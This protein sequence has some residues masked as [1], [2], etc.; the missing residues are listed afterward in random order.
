VVVFFL[1]WAPFHAQRLLVI[2]VRRD[3]WTPELLVLQNG[4]YYVSGV[5]YYVSSVVNPILYSIMSLK[6]RQAFRNIFRS[7]CCSGWSCLRGR[8][9][10]YDCQR[11]LRRGRP[12]IKKRVKT[13]RFSVRFPP[14]PPPPPAAALPHAAA[15]MIGDAIEDSKL[16]LSSLQK[17]LR[18]QNRFPAFLPTSP[19]EGFVLARSSDS[20]AAR[21]PVTTNSVR[22]LAN[23]VARPRSHSGGGGE[24]EVV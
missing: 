15:G 19:Q 11:R 12:V 7:H 21:N 5:L 10:S 17:Q 6:F 22:H 2:Y 24:K 23:V 13:F 1:C 16:A 20:S 3:Q 18:Q 8:R 14:L 9:D 4:L